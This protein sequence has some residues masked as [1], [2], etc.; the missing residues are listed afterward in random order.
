M[1]RDHLYKFSIPLQKKAPHEVWRKLAQGFQRQSCSKVWTTDLRT[2]GSTWSLKQ[3]GSGVSEEK[4]LKGVDHRLTDNDG[5][6]RTASD[7]TS[8]SWAFGSG[9]LKSQRS[10]L[11][12]NF[13]KLSRLWVPDAVY[14]DSA[15][16]IDLT[17]LG[18]NDT[19]TLVGH[20]VSSPRERE[21]K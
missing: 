19:S 18:N 16:E 7:H 12:H 9:E 13:N 5:R 10:S 11:Y 8:S 1:D 3:I 17:E 21:K 2:T 6:R 14:Q 20:F 4:L 15:Y